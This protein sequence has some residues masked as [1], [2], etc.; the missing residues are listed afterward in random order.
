M[1]QTQFAIL[2][3]PYLKP[4]DAQSQIVLSKSMSHG[5]KGRIGNQVMEP[6]TGKVNSEMDRRRATGGRGVFCT[7]CLSR[8][9]VKFTGYNASKYL[10]KQSS[11]NSWDASKKSTFLYT[12]FSL[13]KQEETT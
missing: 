8:G 3:R 2:F 10:S 4:K 9:C 12:H 13:V 1:F 6:P 7:C 5:L 11:Q